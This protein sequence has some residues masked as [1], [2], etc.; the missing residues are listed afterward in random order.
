L[1]PGPDKVG[2]NGLKPTTLMKS[3]TK[4]FKPVMKSLGKTFL[5]CYNGKTK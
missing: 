1:S 5:V 4:K 2:Q 3:L